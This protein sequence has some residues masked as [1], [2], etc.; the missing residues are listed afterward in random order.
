MVSLAIACKNS[1]RVPSTIT[2]VFLPNSI[3]DIPS[4][5]V[6]YTQKHIKLNQHISSLKLS[7]QHKQKYIHIHNVD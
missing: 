6:V 2:V 5:V 3:E 4:I 1:Q 7:K